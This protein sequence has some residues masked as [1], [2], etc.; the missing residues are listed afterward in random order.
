MSKKIGGREVRGAMSR[1]GRA[2]CSLITSTGQ[3]DGAGVGG[4]GEEEQRSGAGGEQE[5]SRKAP[6]Y[7]HGMQPPEEEFGASQCAKVKST[8]KGCCGGGGPPSGEN[9]VRQE[10]LCARLHIA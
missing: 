7:A 6:R 8:C 1:G 10:H 3:G 4:G 5:E 9:Q 2:V